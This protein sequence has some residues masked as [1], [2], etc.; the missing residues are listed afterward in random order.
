MHQLIN[1]AI[2]LG[3]AF[4]GGWGVS[5]FNIPGGTIIG[6]MLSVIIVKLILGE[7]MALPK[8]WP[9]V[10]EVIVGAAVGV[11][12]SPNMLH[13]L[14][15]FAIPILSSALLLILLGSCMAILF[16]KYWGMDLTTAFIST[17]PGAMTAMTGM[18]GGLNIDLFLVLTFHITRIILVVLLAPVLLK[19]C[20]TL[21]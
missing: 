17:S 9:F 18:A 6:A 1:L 20:R 16:S 11:S 12:F 4:L 10:L 3:V 2:I 14:K 8:Q 7:P 5:R 15:F 21:L 13:Q 19:L